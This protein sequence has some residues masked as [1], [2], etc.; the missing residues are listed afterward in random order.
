[1]SCR[2]FRECLSHGGSLTGP[3]ADHLRACSGC[4]M[5][6]ESL[7]FPS[8]SPH[9]QQLARL[10]EQMG[11]TAGAVRPLPSDSTMF[12][13]SL[14]VF[15]AFSMLLVMP[16]GYEGFL[17]LNALQR[18]FEYGTILVLAALL[19]FA[20]VQEMVPGAKRRIDP[21]TLLI[22]LLLLLPLTTVSL[23]PNFSLASFVRRGAPCLRFGLV[24]AAISAAFGFWLIK[25]GY[26]GSPIRAA[27]IFGA[28]AGLVGVAALALHCPVLNAS[29]ILVWHCGAILIGAVAGALFSTVAQVGQAS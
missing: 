19:S 7:Q 9:Q 20:I 17:R 6:L 21:F 15:L 2:D 13:I 8:E 24:C 12:V 11:H 27:A 10:K 5:M 16:V 26:S 25:E 1:V 22:L 29:H 3:A 28:F 23:F 4:R 18:I 14:L